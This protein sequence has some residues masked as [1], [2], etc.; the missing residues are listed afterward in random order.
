MGVPQDYAAVDLETTGLNPKTDKIIEVGIVAVKGG[1]VVQTYSSLVNPYQKLRAE[2]TALTG[3]QDSMLEHAPGIQEIIRDCIE[4]CEDLPLL[5]HKILF[6]YSFL[7]KAAVNEGLEFEKTG[8]DTL[9]LCR[10]FMPAEEKKN[11]ASACS[12]YGVDLNGAHRAF[13]DALATHELYQKMAAVHGES[14]S[15][16]FCPKPLI[17]KIKREQ[18]ATKRQKEVLRELLKYHKISVTAQI[19]HLSRNEISRLTDKIILQY[20]RIAKKGIKS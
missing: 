19:D 2:T 18:P 11:L 4:L 17:Y 15:N 5:G 20:G 1:Q 7:K 3:I 10:K 13:Q 16:E 14:G 8:I 6:D 12:S 9:K